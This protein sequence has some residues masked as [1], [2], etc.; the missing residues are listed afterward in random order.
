MNAPWF[1]AVIH[2][3]QSNAGIIH[4]RCTYRAEHGEGFYKGTYV[5]LE[6]DT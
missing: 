5:L 3:I 6:R 1:H 4:S 2:M